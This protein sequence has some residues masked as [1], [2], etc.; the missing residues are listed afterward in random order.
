MEHSKSP[1]GPTQPDLTKGEHDMNSPDKS[2]DIQTTEIKQYE[3]PYGFR[4]IL[5]VINVIDKGEINH[6]ITLK[7]NHVLDL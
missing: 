6:D 4:F 3:N 5:L 2:R 1:L 7:F